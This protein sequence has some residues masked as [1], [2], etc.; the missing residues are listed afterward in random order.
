MKKY[1]DIN[2]NILGISNELPKW[3]YEFLDELNKC[4]MALN[5]SRGKPIKY[6]SSNRIASL[7]GNGIYTFIDSKTQFNKIFDEDE[8]GSYKNYDDLGSKIEFLLSN[9]KKVNQ[10]GKNGKIKYFKLFNN[11]IITK[12]MISKTF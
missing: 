11:K 2:Y 3:N 7:I 10:Y 12:N 4:K 1:P 6:T 5:L 9:E 8:V